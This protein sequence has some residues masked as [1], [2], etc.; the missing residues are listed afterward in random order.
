M[1]SQFSVYDRLRLKYGLPANPT[2]DQV[3]RWQE[4]TES[5]I[6]LGSGKEQAGR[7]AAASIF[8]GFETRIYA[9]ESETI[10]S[11]LDA[12]RRR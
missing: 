6:R 4:T 2:A 1:A 11:L 10:D 3:R 5:S 7:A 9:S 12:A 8:Q